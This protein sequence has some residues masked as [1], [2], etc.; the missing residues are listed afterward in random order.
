MTRWPVEGVGMSESL[1]LLAS[2]L[3]CSN[4]AGY[5]CWGGIRSLERHVDGWRE[6]GLGKVQVPV[7]MAAGPAILTLMLPL[8]PAPVDMAAGPLLDT[9]PAAVVVVAAPSITG[10]QVEG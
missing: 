1:Q 10:S 2:T 4:G 7:G 9:L 8:A 3:V 5:V 6:E